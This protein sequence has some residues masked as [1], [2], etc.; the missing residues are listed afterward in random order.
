MESSDVL[1][2]SKEGM[3]VS[4]LFSLS[5]IMGYTRPGGMGDTLILLERMSLKWSTS[6]EVVVFRFDTHDPF[7]SLRQE[8]LFYVV[9]RWWW[10]GGT[11]YSGH[12]P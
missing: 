1:I 3:I 2:S 12:L 11:L 9:N 6:V 10:H 8:I 5:G 4:Q 7:S